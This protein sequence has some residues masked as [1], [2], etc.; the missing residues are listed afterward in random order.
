MKKRFWP[1]FPILSNM[2]YV[3]KLF[4]GSASSFNYYCGTYKS[5]FFGL[6]RL[7]KTKFLKKK[8]TLPVKKKL[9]G[10]NSYYRLW[11]TSRNNLQGSTSYFYHCFIIYKSIFQELR[12]WWK[13]KNLREKGKLSSEKNYLKISFPYNRAWQNSSNKLKGPV[14]FSGS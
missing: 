1:I 13:H 8:A 11:Q 10:F 12:G 4:L 6:E 9:T 5:I 2:T 7:L 14:R 3:K